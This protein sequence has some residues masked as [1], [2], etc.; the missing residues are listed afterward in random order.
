MSAVL[1]PREGAIPNNGSPV[2]SNALA[3]FATR[4]S[5]VPLEDIESTLG[6]DKPTASRIRSGEKA[7]SAQQLVRL[8]ALGHMKL[9]DSDKV[10]VDRKAYDSMTYIASK[11]MANQ[12]TAQTLIW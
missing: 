5:R 6:V 9:V 11:A 4:L 1:Q 12:Q 2:E 10:C 3:F 7:V 8:I